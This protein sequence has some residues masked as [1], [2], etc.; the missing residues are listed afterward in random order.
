M[1]NS[2][3]IDNTG[4]SNFLKDMSDEERRKWAKQIVRRMMD[5]WQ[6]PDQKSLAAKLDLNEKAPTNWIQKRSVPWNAVYTC[7]AETGKSL[8]WLYNGKTQAIEITSAM[9]GALE[10]N[11]ATLLESSETMNMLK[12]LDEGATK[13]FVTGMVKSFLKIINKGK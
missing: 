5:A 8:D 10:K 4:G 2:D 13:F 1:P 12:V 7:H 11:T 3:S 9:Q 6:V